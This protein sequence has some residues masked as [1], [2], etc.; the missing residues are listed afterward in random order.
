MI[1]TVLYIN[2]SVYLQC[3]GCLWPVAWNY[4]LHSY[5]EFK[6]TVKTG[7]QCRSFMAKILGF[8]I[9][10][11]RWEM[12]HFRDVKRGKWARND[13]TIQETTYML[14]HL[15]PFVVWKLLPDQETSEAPQSLLDL[16]QK[17]GTL[18]CQTI[19]TSLMVMSLTREA[20]LRPAGSK[21]ARTSPHLVSDCAGVWQLLW[22]GVLPS[23]QLE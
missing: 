6:H 16:A 21:P 12:P 15:L 20:F 10:F 17:T 11:Q 5:L 3:S 8:V 1:Q 22:E 4:G 14:S 2:H 19:P 7:I 9:F 13:F 23:S 18:C